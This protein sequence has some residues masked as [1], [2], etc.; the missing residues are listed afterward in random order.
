MERLFDLDMQLIAD[1]TGMIIAIF[2]LYLALSYFLF[3][4]AKKVLQNRQDRIKNELDEAQSNMEA[5]QKLKAEYEDKLKNIEKEKEEILSEARK[6]ALKNEADIVARA[7]EEAARIMERAHSE[8][9]LEKQKLADDVKKEMITVASAMAGKVVAASMNTQ[10]QEQLIE[11][12]LKEIGD[13]TW[14]S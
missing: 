8:A 5:A 4:P 12:T 9:M 11:D 2:V 7:K 14:L 1:A 6:N 13:S 10:I 3:D